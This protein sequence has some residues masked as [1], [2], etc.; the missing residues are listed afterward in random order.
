MSFMRSDS[1]GVVTIALLLGLDRLD[2]MAHELDDLVAIMLDEELLKHAEM[3]RDLYDGAAGYLWALLLM[4][5][6]FKK[7]ML[8]DS[9]PILSQL[10]TDTY[11]KKLEI[12]II[13]LVDIISVIFNE[14]LIKFT[15][16]SES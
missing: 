11:I 6:E 3:N 8:D 1:I 14:T 9:L 2:I 4:Y 12:R 5:Q 15:V 10:K 13:H 7:R 16:T